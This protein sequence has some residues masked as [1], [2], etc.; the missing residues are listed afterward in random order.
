MVLDTSAV[1]AILFDED[2]RSSFVD[3][4]L[5]DPVRLIT[6]PTLVEASIVA[7]ARAGENAARELDLL[8]DRLKVVVINCT[9]DDA[10]LARDAWRR[11]GK[12]RHRAALNFGD[13]FS[14]AAAVR[15]GEPLLFKGDDFRFT[16]VVAAMPST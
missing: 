14:Y 1:V 2:E 6:A 13:C 7:E 4:V 12:G 8:L 15:T 11:F 5:A 9:E 10:R 16:D 3:A